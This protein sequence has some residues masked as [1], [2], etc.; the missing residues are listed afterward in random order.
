MGEEIRVQS[1]A[2][3]SVVNSLDCY[4]FESQYLAHAR[5]RK[6]LVISPYLTYFGTLKDSGYPRSVNGWATVCTTEESWFYSKRRYV[7]LLQSVHT[8]S[9]AY[10]SSYSVGPGAE[11]NSV[12]NGRAMAQVVSRRPLT[13]EARFRSR[14]SPYGICGGKSGTGTGFSPRVLRFSPVNFIPPVLHY[15]EKRKKLIIFITGLHNK[16]SGCG[17]SVASA[18][19]ICTFSPPYGFMVWCLINY[20]ENFTLSNVIETFIISCRVSLHTACPSLLGSLLYNRSRLG[21]LSLETYRHRT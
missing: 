7:I 6:G 5:E 2:C 17:A 18:A 14:V 8:V 10:P 3:T 12:Y 1:V 11:V 20:R 13:V 9:G 4:F 21:G 19:C 15:K 16:P